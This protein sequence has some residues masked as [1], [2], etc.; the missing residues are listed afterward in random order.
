MHIWSSLPDIA[1]GWTSVSFISWDNTCSVENG[2]PS[3][4]EKRAYVGEA[5]LHARRTSCLSLLKHEDLRLYQGEGTHM[6]ALLPFL[7]PLQK[8]SFSMVLL[9]LEGIAAF[10]TFKGA[11][12]QWLWILN[13]KLK[14]LSVPLSWLEGLGL[15]LL[16]SF[17]GQ[18]KSVV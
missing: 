9:L 11:R 17:K 18:K 13:R 7:L 5:L 12:N 6:F 4:W 14:V 8:Y 10:Q 2:W 1:V 16:L 15:E 3:Q